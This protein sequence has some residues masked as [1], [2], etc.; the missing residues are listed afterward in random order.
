MINVDNRY[1]LGDKVYIITRYKKGEWFVPN[2]IFTIDLIK[3]L[4]FGH[5]APKPAIQIS[6]KIP[7]PYSKIAMYPEARVFRDY[8]NALKHCEMLNRYKLD[9]L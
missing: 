3:V 8:E 7:N 2:S 9:E 1:D 5:L 4:T 6:Y